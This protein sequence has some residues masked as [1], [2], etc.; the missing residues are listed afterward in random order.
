MLAGD[1]HP[2]FLAYS[3]LFSAGVD[4][5]LLPSSRGRGPRPRVFG[6]FS[7]HHLED[8]LGAVVEVHPHGATA[9]VRVAPDGEDLPR[10]G[11]DGMGAGEDLGALLRGELVAPEG[12]LDAREGGEAVADELVSGL[13]V[14]GAEDP[15]V[16]GV[17]RAPGL[18]GDDVVDLDFLAQ[19]APHAAAG[20]GAGAV[21][22]AQ[23]TGA[24]VVPLDYPGPL[25][26]LGGAGGVPGL[27]D[28]PPEGPVGAADD[29]GLLGV[30][31]RAA[32]AEGVGIT[33]TIDVSMAAGA[34]SS[35]VV[36]RDLDRHSAERAAEAGGPEM[37][38]EDP[39]ETCFQKKTPPS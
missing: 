32:L 14:L 18:A 23:H 2:G 21:I 37:R 12:E 33:V 1:S 8:P 4:N 39:W 11:H 7:R 27:R 9:G 31:A 24:D 5:A 38:T 13:V 35:D 36:L 15:E 28:G 34:L 22:A 16:P 29:D 3:C 6:S 20:P 25:V 10:L 19:V 26:V 30:M 17:I